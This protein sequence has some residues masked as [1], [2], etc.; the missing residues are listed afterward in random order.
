[1]TASILVSLAFAVF[2]GCIFAGLAIFSSEPE[3]EEGSVW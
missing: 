3:I 2:A 1:M